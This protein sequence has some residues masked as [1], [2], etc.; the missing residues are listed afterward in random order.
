MRVGLTTLIEGDGPLVTGRGPVRTGVTVILPRGPGDAHEPV[1]AGCHR[2]NGN[3]EMT[4]LEWIRE[5]GMLTTPIAITN[6]HS[7][8]VVRDALVADFVRRPGPSRRVVVAARRRRDVGRPAQRLRT[9]STS[10]RSTCTRRSIR[11][12]AARS[13]KATSAAG[14][15]RSATSSRAAPGRRRASSPRRSAA[16]P[17][18]SLVQANYGKRD[19]LRV[20]G[21]PVGAEIGVDE[22]PSPFGHRAALGTRSI[23][24]ARARSSS[25]SP[26]MRR[27]CR[28]S[29]SGSPS[30][31]GSASRAPAGPAA[32][33]AATCSWPSRPATACRSTTRTTRAAWATTSGRSATA[34]STRCSTASSRRPRKRSST[35]WSPPR[36]WSGATASPHTPCPTIG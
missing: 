21:V 32:T 12:A 29:A 36:R 34:S 8:G 6:T 14:P 17:S 31:P 3:G 4:G 33:R 15:D 20:D 28:T 13:P 26:P 1:F 22:V 23:R 16:T 10:D 25:S 5:S 18:A 7:V 27:S 24:P 11:R 2:L 30:A 9:G 35:P 19:W